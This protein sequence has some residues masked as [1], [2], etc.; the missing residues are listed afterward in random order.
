MTAPT[1]CDLLVLARAALTGDEAGTVL[2]DVAVAVTGGRIV[3]LGARDDVIRAFAPAR[4]LGG[5]HHIL[6]PGLIN[7]HNHTPIMVV[8]GMIED[9]SFAPAYTPG[10]PQGDAL[11]H[12]DALALARLGCYEMLRFGSTTVSDFYRHPQALAQAA[13]ETGLRAFIGGRIMDADTAA[14]ARREWRSDPAKGEAM[15]AEAM[16]VVETWTGRDPLITPVLGPHA[17]DTCSPA[18]LRRVADEA[19]KRGLLV[20]THLH[21]SPMEVEAVLA[22]DGLRPVELMAETGLLNTRLIAGHCIHM[23]DADIARFGAAAAH[24]AH[25]PVGNAAHGSLAPVTALKR[26]GAGITIATD[27]KSGDMFE[28]MRMALAATRLRGEGFTTTARDVLGWATRGGAFAHGL[29]G[30]L[31]QIAPGRFADLVLLDGRSPDLAPLIDGPG[32]IV[33]SAHGAAVDAVVVNGRVVLEDRRPT[34]FDG[35]AVIRDAERV[36]RRLWERHGHQPRIAA[37]P[38]IV[39]M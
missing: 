8:R 4:T 34:L 37:V 23:N 11:S 27:T 38:S 31:G 24:V 30:D 6:L 33:H 3:A 17:P 16:D 36:A 35:D 7:S 22:R 14:L 18:L 13:Q 20:H 21:Q 9:L 15:F 25:V 19:D 12:D 26:A 32:L 28:A 10:V 1:P 29:G 39:R 2:S 5:A